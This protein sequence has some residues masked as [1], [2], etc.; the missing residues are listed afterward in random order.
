MRQDIPIADL[1]LDKANPRLEVQAGSREAA[2][3]LF[4]SGGKKMIRLAEE[5]V[6][7]HGLSPLEKIGVVQVG[8]APARYVVFEGNRRVA[9]LQ[10][11]HDPDIIKG[12]LPA[13]SFKRLKDLSARF[14]ANDPIES[15]ECEVLPEAELQ[16]WM[17][18]RHT[19][20]NE[21]AGVVGWGTEEQARFLERTKGR[22]AIE[23][24][25]LERY[26]DYTQGDEVARARA[27]K[28]PITTLKRLL[29]SAPVRDRLGIS[30]DADGLARSKYPPDEVHKWL[31]KVIDDLAAR[32]VTARTLNKT[33]QMVDYIDSF[34]A[35]ELPDATKALPN[36]LLVQPVGGAA[37]AKAPRSGTRRSS[38]AAWSIKALRIDPASPRLKELIREIEKLPLIEKCPNVH[39]VVFRVF[40]ELATEDY[41]VR[42]RVQ[43]PAEK[44]GRVT[45]RRKIAEV[46]SHLN[47]AGLLTNNAMTAAQRATSKGAFLGTTDLNQWLHNPEFFP[48]AGDV[49]TLWKNLAPYLSA[50]LQS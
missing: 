39:A 29:E 11:L 6:N 49:T 19:G 4:S 47:A 17:A 24:Q 23:L 28:A 25:F 44:D 1:L 41:V 22:R 20:E 13:P 45:L 5:I 34:S 10:A 3:A 30:I 36:P 18:L 48:S 38:P 40:L 26:L 31:G 14:L 9:S 46:A 15:V 2:R 8:S 33:A 16:H 35:H 42:N 43:V 27:K 37:Q 50:L 21:G 7:R 32:R 12:V